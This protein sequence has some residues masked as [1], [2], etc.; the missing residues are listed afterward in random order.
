MDRRSD[1]EEE[2]K[3]ALGI[4]PNLTASKNAL[5]ELLKNEIQF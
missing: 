3:A 5:G 4:D 1:A 2:F